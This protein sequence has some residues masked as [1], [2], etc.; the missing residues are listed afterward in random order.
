M[1]LEQGDYLVEGTG[2]VNSLN[3]N[4]DYDTYLDFKF[5]GSMT[6]I[7]QLQENK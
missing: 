7:L 6:I 4:E 2:V 1:N 5:N 3:Y